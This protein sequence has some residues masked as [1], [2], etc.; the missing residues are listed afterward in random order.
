VIPGL[1]AHIHDAVRHPPHH[2]LLELLLGEV[3]A[4]VAEHIPLSL[5]AHLIL[6]T[7]LAVS[8]TA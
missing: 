7:R 3:G 8:L 4:D 6:A 2:L 1:H 5:L